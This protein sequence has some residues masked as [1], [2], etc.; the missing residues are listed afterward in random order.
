MK[1]ILIINTF[2]IGD[3]L[4][5]TPLV[6]AIKN[7]YSDTKITYICNKRSYDIIRNNPHVSKVYIFE[8]DDYRAIWAESRLKLLKEKIGRAHV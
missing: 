6:R 5:S 1:K 2:G 7:R 4:F 8:K 3:C